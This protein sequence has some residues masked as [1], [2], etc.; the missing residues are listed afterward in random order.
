[1][2]ASLMFRAE[3]AEAI[4]TENDDAWAPPEAPL[5]MPAQIVE[6]ERA[7]SLLEVLRVFLPRQRV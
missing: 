6:R 2:T 3:S 5:A 7:P 1:M 4:K